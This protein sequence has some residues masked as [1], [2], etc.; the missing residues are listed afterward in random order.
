MG[1]V[2]I[3]GVEFLFNK[4][5]QNDSETD[6]IVADMF[7]ENKLITYVE[8][9][10]VTIINYGAFY[11][12][13][14]LTTAIFK[15]LR[16]LGNHVFAGCNFKTIEIPNVISIGNLCFATNQSLEKIVLNDEITEIENS[17]FTQ[18]RGLVN[19]HLP[20]NLE[21]IG[22]RVFFDARKLILTQLPK[23]VNIIP[24]Y[25]FGNCYALTN[26]TLGGKGHPMIAIEDGAFYNCNNLTK[27]TIYTTGGQ[28]LAG[29]PWGA[30]NTTITYLP[31]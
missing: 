6:E 8:M 26:L 1:K 17:T 15:N 16:V 25:C 5:Y 31:A 21:K 28:A 12:C 10:T 13:S 23:K 30:T 18:C 2:V 4:L 7:S 11:G 20:E 9:E 29:A 27:L 3:D 22:S 14:N 24:G 19:I